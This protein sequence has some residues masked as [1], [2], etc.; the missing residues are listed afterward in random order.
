MAKPVLEH[1]IRDECDF[2]AHLDYIHLNPVQ[3]VS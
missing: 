1:L 3:H 2:S